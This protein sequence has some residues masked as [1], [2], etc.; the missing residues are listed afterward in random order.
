MGTDKI[1]H[2]PKRVLSSGFTLDVTVGGIIGLGI[3][4]TPG[5]MAAEL[6]ADIALKALSRH[7]SENATSIAG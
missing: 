5:E 6:V 3:L 4:R 2:R 7:I 1:Q